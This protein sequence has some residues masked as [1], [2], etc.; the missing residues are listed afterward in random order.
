M[1]KDL[2]VSFKWE[3]DPNKR[4]QVCRNVLESLPEWFGIPKAV[5]NY[6]KDV[7]DLPFIVVTFDDRIV[8]FCALKLNY[9]NNADFY[10]L[11]LLKEY[12][13]A[14]IGTKMVSF[15]ETW[16]AQKGISYMTVKTLSERHPDKFYAMTRRFYEKCGFIPLEEFPT[17]WDESNPCLLMIK[18]VHPTA[19]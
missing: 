16:C 12:H 6:V 2:D 8:G 11:G 14:G 15:V 7:R 1:N 10:V 17:L 18:P 9:D 4:S 19:S 13:G 5:E 3:V